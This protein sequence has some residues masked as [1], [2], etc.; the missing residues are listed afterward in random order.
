MQ[1]W[2][3]DLRFAGQSLH[4]AADR[5]QDLQASPSLTIHFEKLDDLTVA[6]NDRPN[7]G[8]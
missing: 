5:G 8:D 7:W 1:S 4:V 2:K 6:G 3:R